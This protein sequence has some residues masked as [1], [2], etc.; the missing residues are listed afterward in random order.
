MKQNVRMLRYRI[1][2]DAMWHDSVEHAIWTYEHP[3]YLEE[4]TLVLVNVDGYESVGEI[5]YQGHAYDGPCKPILEVLSPQAT[6][7]VV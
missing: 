3:E 5:T 1:R 7:V 6:V 4:G 2:R